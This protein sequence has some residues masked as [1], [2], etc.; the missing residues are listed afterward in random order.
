MGPRSRR[1]VHA[2]VCV[3]SMKESNGAEVGGGGR[4]VARTTIGSGSS[5][6]SARARSCSVD[7]SVHCKSSKA[8][9]RSGWSPVVAAPR[10]SAIASICAQ[11]L[12]AR[13]ASDRS[14]SDL[15][16]RLNIAT[17]FGSDASAGGAEQV[18]DGTEWTA[19]ITLVRATES[20]AD[21]P[22]PRDGEGLTEEPR[23][24]DSG[25][26]R[27]K[28]DAHS[29]ARRDLV[30]GRLDPFELVGAADHRSAAV[31]SLCRGGFR[32]GGHR[33]SVSCSRAPGASPTR[34][35]GVLRTGVLE[36]KPNPANAENWQPGATL[37]T[38]RSGVV[39]TNLERLDRTHA[40]PMPADDTGPG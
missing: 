27:H 13:V 8:A 1:S 39:V 32:G 20:E 30:E 4:N 15:I 22:P 24:A 25:V 31:T 23:L 19:R 29:V 34:S 11:R 12:T 2:R 5:W 14:V 40:L 26:T 16:A 17:L 35:L 37:A 7:S 21:A 33:M 18:D 28:Q 3:A 6:R 38:D 9:R 36:S 10:A